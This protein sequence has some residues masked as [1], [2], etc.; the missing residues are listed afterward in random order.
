M[1]RRSLALIASDLLIVFLPVSMF[2]FQAEWTHLYTL[3]P[4]L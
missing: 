3:F 2:W 4:D 1:L